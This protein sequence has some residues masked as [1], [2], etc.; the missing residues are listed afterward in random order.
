MGANTVWVALATPNAPTGGIPF[1]DANNE[2]DIDVTRFFYDSV[3][4]MMKILNG[5][6][7]DYTFAGVTGAQVINKPAGTVLF[8]AAAQTLVVTNSLVDANSL[9]IP[10]VLGDDAT[11]KSA[12]ISVQAAG[13]FTIKLN[14]VAAAQLKVGFLVFPLGKPIAQ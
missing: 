13:S 4:F 3:Q 1:I 2:P 6:A 5:I 10:F 11:A 12:V 7:F 14:A 9:I 8:A